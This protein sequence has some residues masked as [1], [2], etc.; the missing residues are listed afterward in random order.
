MKN[1]CIHTLMLLFMSAALTA[2]AQ[3]EEKADIDEWQT[4]KV[5]AARDPFE[6]KN[7]FTINFRNYTVEEYLTSV[8][9]MLTNKAVVGFFTSLAQW[10]LTSTRSA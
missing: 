10:G 6:K 8:T 4:L 1:F 5:E 3:D 9:E 2:R 7:Q